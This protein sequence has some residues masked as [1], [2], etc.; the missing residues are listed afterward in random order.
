LDI[1][2]PPSPAVIVLF[3]YK[4]AQPKSPNVPK[5]LPL[6]LEPIA[7]EISSI[8]NSSFSSHRVRIASISDGVP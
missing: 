8:K 2:K 4:E 3:A 5:Y 7:S 1:V 6:Y